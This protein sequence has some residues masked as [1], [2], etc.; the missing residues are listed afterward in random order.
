MMRFDVFIMRHFLPL[1][2]VLWGS[3]LVGCGQ[4]QKKHLEP[5]MTTRQ[6]V[7]DGMDELAKFSV[8]TVK[9]ARARIADRLDDIDW[10]LAENA[11][12]KTAQDG[13]II[14]DW[15]R[16]K[17]FLKDGPDRLVGLKKEGQL[18]MDQL[19]HLMADIRSNVQKDVEGTII[20]DAYLEQA[21]AAE[22]L[23]ANQFE[24]AVNETS[25]LV[26]LGL[27]LEREARPS[28]D[29]LILAK[30]AEWVHQFAQDP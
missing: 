20:D 19:D 14:G 7:Q 10:L 2:L 3:L 8:D 12:T 22:I 29:S 6:Q 13:E 11:V 18:C 28:V 4:S 26:R 9:A 17:R 24:L 1:G 25:R 30:R 15:S 27:E 23:A 5:L 21:S 16:A